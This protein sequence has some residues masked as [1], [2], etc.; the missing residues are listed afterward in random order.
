MKRLQQDIII[1]DLKK[2]YVFLAGPRQ[3]GKTT[4]ATHVGQTLASQYLNYDLATD[5]QIITAG[6]WRRDREVIVLDE[7]HKHPKWKTFLK[8]YYDTEGVPPSLLVTGSARLNVYRKGNDSMLGRYYYHRLLPLSVKEVGGDAENVLDKLLKFG[9]FP[10]PYLT[11]DESESSR[12]KQQYI[13]RV[14]REDVVDL[15]NVKLINKL[16]LL[17]DLLRQRVG[18]SVSYSALA[19]DLEVASST[20]KDWIQVLENLYLI[21][22]VTPYH[23][24]IARS[25]LKEPKI[26]FFDATMAFDKSAHLENL[27]AVSILKHLFYLEDTQGIRGQLNYL[28]VKDGQEVDFLITQ[29]TKPTAMIEVKSSDSDLH[30]GLTYFSKFFPSIETYQ[31]VKTLPRERDSQNVKVRKVSE[32]LNTLSI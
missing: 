21:F 13:E 23:K 9:N 4:L 27:V 1:K 2:K 12:W 6:E 16:T 22:I 29:D 3:S 31:I 8:G 28:R 10:E 26:Y 5:R 15:S 7:V 14:V 30:K 20:I 24:N 18:K 32:Y 11:E 19:R 25:L 17:I